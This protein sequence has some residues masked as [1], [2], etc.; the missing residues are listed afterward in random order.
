[1]FEKMD[2]IFDKEHLKKWTTYLIKNVCKN[3]KD[4]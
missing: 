3:G 1:M 4:I 2:K